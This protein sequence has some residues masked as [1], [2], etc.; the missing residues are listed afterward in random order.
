[1]VHQQGLA[2]TNGAG[3]PPAEEHPRPPRA[4]PGSDPWEDFRRELSRARRYGHQFVLIRIPG[5]EVVRKAPGRLPKRPRRRLEQRHDDGT[6]GFASLLRTVDLSW[7]HR[8]DVYLLLP[9]S[10]RPMGEALLTRIR[11]LAPDVL[12]V[13]DVRMVVFPEDG[14][15]SGALLTALSSQPTATPQAEAPTVGDA[16]AL[17]HHR[18]ES[19]LALD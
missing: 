12:P 17:R 9:E 5:G 13:S 7:S 18:E 11:Q 16:I 3:E 19:S 1:M 4:H 2:S 15:T 10:D 6:R 8:G 14:W